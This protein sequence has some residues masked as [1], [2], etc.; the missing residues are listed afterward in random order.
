[1]FYG[2]PAEGNH[3]QRASARGGVD[4]T[5]SRL[6][7]H[8]CAHPMCMRARAGV[9]HPAFCTGQAQ[10]RLLCCCRASILETSSG[11]AGVVAVCILIW[12]S[13]GLAPQTGRAC[14]ADQMLNQA[15]ELITKQ[16]SMLA[17]VF[18]VGFCGWTMKHQCRVDHLFFFHQ[19]P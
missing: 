5:L 17:I 18:Q 12:L 8:C 16:T 4:L 9:W 7:S 2:H 14:M 19:D 3:V 6:T 11:L 10:S 1:M 15:P 13:L